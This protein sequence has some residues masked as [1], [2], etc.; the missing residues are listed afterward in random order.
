MESNWRFNVAKAGLNN[1]GINSM[2]FNSRITL[3]AELVSPIPIIGGH[4]RWVIQFFGSS[5]WMYYLTTGC[6]PGSV[7]DFSFAGFDAKPF[8]P[9][10]PVIADS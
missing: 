5:R 2:E 6:V 4:Y 1:W 10:F 3:A 9:P 8:H 7:I